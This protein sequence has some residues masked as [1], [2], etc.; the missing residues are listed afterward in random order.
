LKKALLIYYSILCI[1]IAAYSKEPAYLHYGVGDGLPSAMVYCAFQDSKGFIW[2]GTAN[3]LV[4]F[5]GT[6]FKVIGIKD[7]LP[8]NGVG[9]EVSREKK[10]KAG[11]TKRISKG[12][13]LLERKVETLNQ[14]YQKDIKVEMIDRS[15]LGGS[16]HGTQA[17]ISYSF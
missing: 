2:F 4:R 3:G 15:R 5:D 14:L 13:Q 10:A 12:I 7:G 17:T 6:R 1:A 11:G 16:A 8:D 9:I